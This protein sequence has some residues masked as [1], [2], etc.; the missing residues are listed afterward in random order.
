MQ[1]IT[2]LALFVLCIPLQA[3]PCKDNNA[4]DVAGAAG[5]VHKVIIIGGGVAGLSSAIY[6]A[7]SELRPLLFAG[8]FEHK[9]GLLIKTSVVENFP[10]FPDG[11][12]GFDLIQNMEAQAK[13]Y[14]TEVVDK[15]IIRVDFS[16]R[17]FRLIDSDGKSYRAQ[18]VIIATGSKPNK[19]GLPN[20][21][22]LWTHGI[23]SCAVCD[24]ALYRK[25]KIA[26]V[27]GGDSA[28]EEALFLTKFSDVTLIH[29]RDSFAASKIMQSKVLGN[30][31]VHVLY[32]TVVTTLNG[33]TRLESIKLQTGT[34]H[35]ESE[36]Q[37][38][39]LFYGLGLTPNSKLF[40]GVLDID[41]AGY[42]VKHP[43][44]H[45][46]TMTSVRGVFV[47]GDVSD[48]IYR[49]AVIAAGDGSKAALDVT[50]YLSVSQP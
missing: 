17:P 40:K 44:D 13:K 36:L 37:V 15:D 29:R 33:T 32:D 48:K 24:G 6:A 1:V 21:D 14:G 34:S 38:D 35:T 8:D 47:A 31:K 3:E 50:N 7:R 19:L 16:R 4:P 30:P 12:E 10:G 18:T 9:G 2:L 42:I 22:K 23:S 45:Y 20:E 49:Q 27:G 39:G 11:I 26:V 41:S 46:E 25:K 28:L 5:D 43:V